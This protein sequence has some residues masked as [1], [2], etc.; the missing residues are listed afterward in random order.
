MTITIHEND[1]LAVLVT[2]VEN[3]SPKNITGANVSAASVD[4]HNT[5][6]LANA[7]DVSDGPNGQLT[8]FFDKDVLQTGARFLQ[9]RVEIGLESQ[10]VANETLTVKP[11]AV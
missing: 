7:A 1:S 9:V 5:A 4:R 6:T 11:A 8:V 2:V 3:G 10:I